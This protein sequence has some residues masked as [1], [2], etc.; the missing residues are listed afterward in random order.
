VKPTIRGRARHTKPVTFAVVRDLALT[1]PG[2]EEGTSYGTPAFKVRGKLFARLRE[3]GESLVVRVDFV[4]RETL[5]EADPKTF[6]I[7]EHYRNHPM[8]LVGLSTVRPDELRELLAQSWRSVAPTRLATALEPTS[9][10][11]RPARR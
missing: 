6:Y 2:A 1:L 10:T 3:D 5:M 4:Q 11:R 8:M 7:T 9:A